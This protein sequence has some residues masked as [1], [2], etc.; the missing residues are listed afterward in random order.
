V[1]VMNMKWLILLIITTVSVQ[2]LRLMASECDC[3]SPRG[4]C[5]ASISVY[6]TGSKKGVYGADL[7]FT[8]ST[9]SCAKVEYYVD[10]TPFFT[11]LTN[12]RGE[13]RVLGDSV[14]PVTNKRVSLIRCRVCDS[15]KSVS[16]A[17]PKSSAEEIFGNALESNSTF[18]RNETDNKID[19]IQAGDIMP[20]MNSVIG[21]VLDSQRLQQSVE[22][23]K[24]TVTAPRESQAAQ[25]GS[26]QSSGATSDPDSG[27]SN[28][29]LDKAPGYCATHND[30]RCGIK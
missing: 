24:G 6:S 26:K 17:P 25:T 10:S 23:S 5:T 8:T 28:R 16:I 29:T 20:S 9:Q 13:D 22:G 27:N 7:K 30:Y 18:D 3:S 14:E 19:E 1:L 21:V 12:G 15:E 4:D 2:S 11:L